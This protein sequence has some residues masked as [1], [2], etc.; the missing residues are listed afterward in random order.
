M[1]TGAHA[2]ALRRKRRV[3]RPGHDRHRLLEQGVH[4]AIV[5]VLV[6]SL[7]GRGRRAYRSSPRWHDLDRDATPSGESQ[8]GPSRTYGR[9]HT[10]LVV[11]DEDR[12]PP[13]RVYLSLS[14]LE[15]RDARATRT[16]RRSRM[17]QAELVPGRLTARP[18]DLQDAGAERRDCHASREPGWSRRG[19]L[20]IGR[21]VKNAQR[22]PERLT[23]HQTS[24]TDNL[25]LRDRRIQLR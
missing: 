12:A 18:K 25:E 17:A 8:P 2:C 24:G 9:H 14:S 15:G 4:R 5:Y 22:K 16:G 11:H 1:I 23:W 7:I 21:R 6:V 13:K 19:H 20:R 3:P 10:Q